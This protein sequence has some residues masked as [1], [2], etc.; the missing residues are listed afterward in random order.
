MWLSRRTDGGL[1]DGEL[2]GSDGGTGTEV[3]LKEV[4]QHCEGTGVP[5]ERTMPVL[6]PFFQP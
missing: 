3:V 1:V 5:N 2:D 6:S 4:G